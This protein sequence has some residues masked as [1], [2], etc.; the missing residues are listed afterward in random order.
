MDASFDKVFVIGFIKG[1]FKNPNYFYVLKF[2]L[3]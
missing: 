1:C 3:M 2:D